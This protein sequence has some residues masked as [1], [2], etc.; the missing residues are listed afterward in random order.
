MPNLGNIFWRHSRFSPKPPETQTHGDFNVYFLKR[1]TRFSLYSANVPLPHV[2]QHT[3]LSQLSH[4]SI[5]SF[6][7]FLFPRGLQHKRKLYT[8]AAIKNISTSYFSL[9]LSFIYLT[10]LARKQLKLNTRTL[11][12]F[13]AKNNKLSYR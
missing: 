10:N 3:L 4:N 9:S 6:Y 8:H 11:Q 2:Q 12:L 1:Q 5:S 13:L 7:F